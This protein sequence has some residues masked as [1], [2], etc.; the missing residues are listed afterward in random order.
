M[1]L[2]VSKKEFFIAVEKLAAYEIEHLEFGKLMSDPGQWHPDI[3]YKRHARKLLKDY[4]N[5]PIKEYRTRGFKF[6]SQLEAPIQVISIEALDIG[7][8]ELYR[9]L[10][11]LQLTVTEYPF[12]RFALWTFLDAYGKQRYVLH[13]LYP[14]GRDPDFFEVRLS[15]TYKDDYPLDHNADK[16]I[17]RFLLWLDINNS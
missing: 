9:L 10:D 3:W 8:K 2:S 1:R 7:I 5:M 16:K 12:Q 15:D 4:L 6:S 17:K 14:L 11:K 13:F